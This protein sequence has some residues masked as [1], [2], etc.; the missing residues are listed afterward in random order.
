MEMRVNVFDARMGF[1]VLKYKHAGKKHRL[2]T[3]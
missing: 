3:T 1:S 2:R